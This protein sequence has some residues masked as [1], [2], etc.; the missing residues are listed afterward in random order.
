[1]YST[2]IQAWSKGCIVVCFS[3]C[4]GFVAATCDLVHDG[5]TFTLHT[6]TATAARNLF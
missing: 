2:V 6:L 1:M 4:F 3:I 5:E